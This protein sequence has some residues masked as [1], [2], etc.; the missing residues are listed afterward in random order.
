MST[1]KQTKNQKAA[2][3]ATAKRVK[4]RPPLTKER[5]VEVLEFDATIGR[6]R[7]REREGNQRFNTRYAGE[8]AGGVCGGGVPGLFYRAIGIDTVT[9]KEHRLVWLYHHGVWPACALDHLN[10]DG[11]DNRLENLRLDTDGVNTRNMAK[12]SRNTSGYTNVCWYAPT[13]KWRVRVESKA[14]RIFGGDFA[15]LDK[16]VLKAVGLREELGYSPLHG[17]TREERKSAFDG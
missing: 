2:E 10:G 5:L 1:V 7:W 6:F 4:E 9:Y 3:A 17:L 11:L 16:A 14:G 13:Q 12:Y 15:E 8:L